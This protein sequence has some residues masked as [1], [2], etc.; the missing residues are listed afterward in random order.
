MNIKYSLPKRLDI[1]ITST[2]TNILYQYLSNNYLNFQLNYSDNICSFLNSHTNT[3]IYNKILNKIPNRIKSILDINLNDQIMM[4]YI[5]N[6]FI[7]N[8]GARL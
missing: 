4:T 8:G 6:E 3:K 2:D 5:S 7:A 1:K